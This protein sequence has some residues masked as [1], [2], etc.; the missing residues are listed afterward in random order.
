MTPIRAKCS[1]SFLASEHSI[2]SIIPKLLDKKLNIK[3]IV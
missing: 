3:D 2:F 1:E